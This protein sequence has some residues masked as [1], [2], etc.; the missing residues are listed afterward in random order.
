MTVRLLLKRIRIENK[1]FITA[2]ELKTYCKETNTDYSKVVTYF[3]KKKYVTRIFKGIF[4]LRPFDELKLGR[5][6]YSHLELVAKGLELKGVK[7]WYFGLHSALKLNNMTHEHFSVE[8]VINN[9]ILRTK[10]IRIAGHKFRFV[11]LSRRADF[12]VNG[13]MVRYSDPERTVLDFIYLWR[14]E[15]IPNERIV[16][17]VSEWAKDVSHSTLAK[18]ARKYPK[19][20]RAIAREVAGENTA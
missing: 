17:D 8:E 2:N 15:G 14:Q 3:L 20:V 11:K 7:D 6:K 10:P 5:S 12:G 9:K 13:E 18:Y 4:Y 19:T 1:E 16:A